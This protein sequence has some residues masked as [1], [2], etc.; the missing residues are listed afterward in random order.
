MLELELARCIECDEVK[1]CIPS[2]WQ[3]LKTGESGV[4]YYC[5]ECDEAM[6]EWL[7]RELELWREKCRPVVRS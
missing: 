6:D 2:P 5:P 7:D 3:S 4:N 1:L